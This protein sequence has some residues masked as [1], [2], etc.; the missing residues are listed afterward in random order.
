MQNHWFAN[1]TYSLPTKDTDLGVVLFSIFTNFIFAWS[2]STFLQF[3]FPIFQRKVF[4]SNTFCQILKK[5]LM[6]LYLKDIQEARRAKNAPRCHWEKCM[7]CWIFVGLT[8]W[9][10][11]MGK[12]QTLADWQPT[13][14]T[15]PTLSC[16]RPEIW[17]GLS[18]AE[19]DDRIS[20][21]V[22]VNPPVV[23]N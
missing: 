19:C 4:E 10:V 22:S 12:Y 6:S 21:T 14:F 11:V 13:P 23:V 9:C 16:W 18:W 17:A 20:P 8:S 7:L 1:T 3:Y 5:I 2:S 15:L